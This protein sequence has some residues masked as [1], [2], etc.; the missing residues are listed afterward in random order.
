MN[1]FQYSVEA[2]MNDSENVKYIQR[3]NCANDLIKNWYDTHYNGRRVNVIQ[4]RIKKLNHIYNHGEVPLCGHGLEMAFG[5]GESIFVLSQWYKN[6]TIDAFDFN[7]LLGK[8]IPFIK[9]LNEKVL[10]MWIG[11]AQ[12]IPKPDNYYDFINSC[13][14]FEHLPEDVFWNSV[15]EAYRV[16]KRGKMMGVYLDEGENKGEHIRCAAVDQTKKELESV[17]FVAINNYLYQKI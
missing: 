8:I 9:E 15:K 1:E 14:F 17:G 2:L 11:D 5:F 3:F 12:K 7:P 6:I 4:N 16:L 13:S 10:E